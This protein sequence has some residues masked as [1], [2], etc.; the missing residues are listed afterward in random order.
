MVSVQELAKILTLYSQ[1]IVRNVQGKLVVYALNSLTFNKKLVADLLEE[2]R[3]FDIQFVSFKTADCSSKSFDSAVSALEKAVVNK[4]SHKEIFYL[5]ENLLNERKYVEALLICK[6]APLYGYLNKRVVIQTMAICSMNMGQLKESLSYWKDYFSERNDI[7]FSKLP[8]FNISNN[9][10]RKI[11]PVV[12]L[13]EEKDIVRRKVCIYTA[14][15]GEYDCLPSVLEASTDIDYICFTD[16]KRQSNGWQYIVVEPSDLNPILENRKYKILPHHYLKQY[17]YSLYIDSNILIVADVKFLIDV[18]QSSDFVAWKHPE[19][20]DVYDE[21]AMII[22]NYRHEPIKMMEQALYFNE[23]NFKRDSG[24]IEACFLWRNHRN[25][26]IIELMDDWWSFIKFRGNRDQPAFTYLMEVTKTRP[27]VFDSKYGDTRFNDFFV[28]LKHRGDPLSISPCGSKSIVFSEKLDRV[29]IV[30]PNANNGRGYLLYKMLKSQ[31]DSLEILFFE[32]DF[33]EVVQGALVVFSSEHYSDVCISN[34][35]RTKD[36]G[37]LIAFDFIDSNINESYV[38]LC[39]VLI[40]SSIGQLL[41]FK[42]IYPEKQSHLVSYFTGL[43]AENIALFK[44]FKRSYEGVVKFNVKWKNELSDIVKLVSTENLTTELHHNGTYCHYGVRED[45][46]DGTNIPFIEG[47]L[48]AHAQVPIIVPKS[49]SDARFY[50]TS[51]YPYLCNS[52]S[53][54]DVK[55]TV[56]Y[57]VSSKGTSTFNQAQEIMQSVQFRS[58][59]EYVAREFLSLIKSL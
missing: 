9:Y 22:S 27:E 2:L 10:Q 3:K 51:D 47:F 28:K 17:E 21:L 41:S 6:C 18:C 43:D 48:S 5:T 57:V 8:K 40:A 58:S 26:R 35:E 24:M 39:N 36:N 55:E 11:F 20:S 16:R 49:Y 52:D 19:R 30:S 44:F 38:E 37:N 15:F 46:S 4:I 29:I 34:V 12:S 56:E 45:Y 23:R 1:P 13:P 32:G 42:K 50:L 31:V 25:K 7:K 54:D 59:P 53:L 14:L 33:N